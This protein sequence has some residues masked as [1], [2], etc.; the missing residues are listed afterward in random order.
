LLAPTWWRR[1]SQC[2]G[3]NACLTFGGRQAPSCW[4]RSRSRSRENL[5]SSDDLDARAN[6]ALDVREQSTLVLGDE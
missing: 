5:G 6:E 1:D 3:E 2:V 4:G